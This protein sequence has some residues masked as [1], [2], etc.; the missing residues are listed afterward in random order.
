MRGSRLYATMT[1]HIGLLQHFKLLASLPNVTLQ[2]L[3]QHTQEQWF[4]KREIVITKGDWRPQALGLLLEGR[5]QGVDFTTDGREVGL[6][7]INPGDYFAEVAAIDNSP[8]PEHVT[9]VAKSRVLLI[10]KE[11]VR[12][13]LFG[14]PAV[15]EVLC[16]RL[17]G[18]LREHV[19]QR[20]ILGLPNP[21]QRVCAQLS[22]L[23]QRKDGESVV[24]NAPT[25]QELAIMINA[26]RET[27]TRAFQLLQGREVVER[28]GND[29]IVLQPDLLLKVASGDIE[30]GKDTSKP[31]T[32]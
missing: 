2:H 32:A 12:P 22:V 1:I 18:R 4:N 28:N 3:A 15:A 20:R 10:P 11:L 13:I 24:L 26:S 16:M 29:L 23:M 14:A 5:L 27:V 25:H 6:Y 9:A 7:F 8:Q 21:L 31:S 17:A 19:A 30:I